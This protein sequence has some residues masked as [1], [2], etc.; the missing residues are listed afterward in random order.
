MVPVS[1]FESD[2]YGDE[3]LECAALVP[4]DPTKLKAINCDTDTVHSGVICQTPG[5]TTL[6][7]GKRFMTRNS[8]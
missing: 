2:S 3:T 8:G 6:M 4:G 5:Y 1:E 7:L